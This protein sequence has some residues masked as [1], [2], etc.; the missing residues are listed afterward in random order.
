MNSTLAHR[1]IDYAVFP[2]GRFLMLR[3]L[4]R[5][6]IALGLGKCD[7]NSN[8]RPEARRTELASPR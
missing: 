6:E 8:T 5:E 4:A 2:D 3:S 7:V 1:M